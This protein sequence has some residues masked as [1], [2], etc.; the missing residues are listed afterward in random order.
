MFNGVRG[1]P[2]SEARDVLE[3]HLLPR[4]PMMKTALGKKM[5]K[6]RCDFIKAFMARWDFEEVGQ[7]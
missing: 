3:T 2:L 4:E 6:E 5:A 7:C 1:E